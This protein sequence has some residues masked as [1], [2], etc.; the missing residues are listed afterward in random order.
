MVGVVIYNGS[1]VVY[2]RE[3]V[4]LIHLTNSQRDFTVTLPSTVKHLRASAMIILTNSAENRS[5][6]SMLII[7]SMYAWLISHMHDTVNNCTIKI[8]QE[9][10]EIV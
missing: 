4:E 2:C 9:Q 8:M 6:E 10:S 3:K 1:D 7:L 5:T